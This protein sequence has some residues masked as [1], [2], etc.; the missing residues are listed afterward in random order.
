[1]LLIR[2][3]SSAFDNV[4]VFSHDSKNYEKDLPRN[5]RHIRLYSRFFYI[6]FGWMVVLFYTRMH[7]LMVLRLVGAASLPLAFMVNRLASTR[8]IIKYYYLWWNSTKGFKRGMVRPVERMLVR[9]VDHVIAGNNEVRDFVGNKVVPIN[10]GIIMSRITGAKPSPFMKK[11]GG[12]KII[13]VGR[14]IDIK[15]PITM[16]RAHKLC[17][18]THPD[19]HLV[20]CGDGPLMER[21]REEAGNNVHFLGFSDKVPEL[22][23][24]ADIFAITSRY[25]A[26]PRALMEAM[27]AGLPTV[28]TRVGGIPEY[29]DK[30]SGILVKPGN[31]KEFSEGISCLLKNPKMASRMGANAKKNIGMNH[32]LEMELEKELKLLGAK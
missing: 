23:K 10:E 11:L 26:S 7:R 2:K 15:D 21:C 28:A 27:A 31:Q 14:L 1:M 8:V 30:K 25:D 17:L 9:F 29:L 12:K 32:N 19:L 24:G 5:C 6:L 13:F 4:L 20:V 22:L 3:Y 18:E 16:I